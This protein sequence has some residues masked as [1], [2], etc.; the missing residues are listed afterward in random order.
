LAKKQ[1]SA[2]DP[3]AKKAEEVE[4]MREF[5]EETSFSGDERDTSG[6]LSVVDQHPADVSPIEEQR[7]RDLVIRQLLD[8]EAEQIREAQRRKA[9]GSYGICENCG[10]RISEARLEARPEATLCIDCQREREQGA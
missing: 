10:R 2:E 5:V 1:R 8:Q 3:L 9:E 6:E 7:S 4:R